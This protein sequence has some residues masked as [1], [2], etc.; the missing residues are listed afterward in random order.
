MGEYEDRVRAIGLEADKEIARQ[1][2][3]IGLLQ[4]KVREL[5]REIATLKE[6]LHEHGLRTKAQEG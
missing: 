4:A 1:D 2:K 3:V 5:R 6:E